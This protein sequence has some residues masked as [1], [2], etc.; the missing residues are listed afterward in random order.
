PTTPQ[1]PA[2]P[3]PALPGLGGSPRLVVHLEGPGGTV[4][5]EAALAAMAL[6]HR[7]GLD[8]RLALLGPADQAAAWTPRLAALPDP[9]RAEYLALEGLDPAALRAVHRHARLVLPG[10]RPAT[11][12]A[13]AVFTPLV[14]AGQ[15]PP[16]AETILDNGTGGFSPDGREYRI[17]IQPGPDGLPVLPPMPWSNVMA[18]ETFGLIA[19]ERGLSCTWNLNSRLRRLTPWLNDPI[20]DPLP[21]TLFVRDE[22]ARAYWS[23]MP[24]PA[25][26]HLAFTVRHGFG[27]T[28][29]ESRADG[30]EQTVTVFADLKDPVRYLTVRITN[31]SGRRRRLGLVW[32]AQLALAETPERSRG[33]LDVRREEGALLAWNTAPGPFHGQVAFASALGGTVRASGDRA[34]YLGPLGDPAAPA[35][36]TSAAGLVPGQEIPAEPGFA[37]Q[38][39]LQL[40]PG[41]T[42]ETVFVFGEATSLR[43]A[44]VLAGS[45]A[46]AA[47][48]LDEVKAFWLRTLSGLR[49]ETPEPALDVMVNGWL[50]YQNLACRMWG[51]TAYYQ[52]GGAYGFR[53]QLQDSAGLLALLPDLARNQLLLHAAHQFV[54]GD[55]LHWWHPPVEEGI[56][57]R[58]SDDLCWLPLL[59]AHYVACTGD[60]AVLDETAPYL[61]APALAPGQ[62]EAYLAPVDSG[63]RGNLYEHCCRALD[64]ALS[65]EGQHGLPLMGTGDWNDGMN[66]VGREGRGESVWMAFFLYAILEA[67]EPLCLRRGDAARAEAFRARR[68][69]LTEAL[70]RS[71][72]DGGWYRRAYF[73]DGTPLGG[74]ANPECRIDCLAQAWARISGAVPEAR[75]EQALA[76]MEAQL[77]DEDARIIRLLTPAF[78]KLP[79]DPGYIK[80]YLPGVRENGGQYTHGALWAV[81]AIAASGRR[82]RAAQLLAMM[83]PVAHAADPAR[84]ARYQTEPYVVAADVYGVGGLTGRGGWTWYTGSAGWMYRVAV[85]DVLGFRLDRG[86]GIRLDPRI[87]EGWPRA[88]LTYRDPRTGAVVDIRVDRDPDLASGAV[89]A[90]LDGMPLEPVDGQLAVPFGPAGAFR[91]LRVRVGA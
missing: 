20:A 34:A 62:D 68:A 14:L 18:S 55:V 70:E 91:V 72:W 41:E 47:A 21:E 46:R 8:F 79:N 88:A 39:A 71:A 4:R 11:A 60:A 22:E 29:W 44:R 89:A 69:R 36:V 15:V 31:R 5:G 77:V 7:Q 32:A 78:D 51:R 67:F 3:L 63:E 53:D 35:A 86:E 23:P 2:H 37:L 59:T 81:K 83:S 9:A 57:T 75:A 65:R 61:T 10:E 54:E 12:G 80:G 73:D 84:V 27:Y 45:G 52:S 50:A 82:G 13:P 38:A 58:F 16:P 49:I 28:A 43:E 26:R 85:E 87:P 33:L 66:R 48:V 42:T 6:W 19:T 30:L 40:E 74:A 1:D 56:R 24:G 64:L 90:T 76:A 25:G 17:R